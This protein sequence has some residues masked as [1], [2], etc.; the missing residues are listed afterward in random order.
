MQYGVSNMRMIEVAE[1]TFTAALCLQGSWGGR[2]LGKHESTMTLYMQEDDKYG[3]IEWDIPSLDEVE[4]IGLWFEDG[5]LTD[6]DGVFSL[7]REAVELLRENDY[8]VGP[9]FLDEVDDDS[10]SNGPR[11]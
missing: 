7:P 3:C 4:H 9:D 11:R 8:V 10:R 5:E 1:K 2:G 6:Y